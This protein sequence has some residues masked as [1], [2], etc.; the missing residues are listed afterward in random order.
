MGSWDVPKMGNYAAV[1][2]TEFLLSPMRNDRVQVDCGSGGGG[3]GTN[4]DKT[5]CSC[6]KAAISG[7]PIWSSG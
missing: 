3:K 4:V 1:F 7:S 2:H 6:A 5:L